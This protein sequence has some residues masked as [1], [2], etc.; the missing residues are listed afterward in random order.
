MIGKCITC[1]SEIE[2]IGGRRY[3]TPCRKVKNSAKWKIY[4]EQRPAAGKSQ[5]VCAICNGM[6][7]AQSKRK[8][9]ICHKV[10]CQNYFY[11]LGRK[12]Q[13][14]QKRIVTAHHRLVTAKNEFEKIQG[15]QS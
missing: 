5:Y 9:N 13:V 1:K 11:S 7:Y 6:F 14:L 10:K 15:M 12:I 2:I 3:C 4:N 8:H